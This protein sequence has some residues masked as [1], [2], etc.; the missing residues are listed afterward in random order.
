[1]QKFNNIILFGGETKNENMPI[2]FYSSLALLPLRGKPIIYRQLENLKN[3]YNL[4]EFIIVVCNDNHKLIKY[5]KNVLKLQFKIKLV[6]V[7]SKKNILSSLK[8]GLK[9]ADMNSPTRV[10]LG[11][12]LIPNSIDDETNIVY[13]SKDITTSENWC[14]I[15]N[16][17]IFYDKLKEID[18]SNKE[19]LVGYYAFSDTKY[20]LNCCTKA[21]LLL[22]KEI[23]TALI[24][25]QKRYKLNKKLIQDWYDLGHTSGIIKTKNLLFNARCFNSISVDMEMGL[26]KKTSTKIQKLEDEAF[27]YENLPKEL[28]ILAPRLID[29]T[30]TDKIGKLTQE[31]Y[32]YP[33]LQELYLSGEVNIEDWRHIIEK[34]FNLHKKLE[35]YKNKNNTQSIK[36]LYLEKTNDRIEELIKQNSYWKNIFDKKFEFINNKKY[37]GI[38]YLKDDI[39]KFIDI[40]CKTPKE[41]IIHGDYCFSNILFDANNYIFK[42]I[43][44]RGRMNAE[45]TIYGDPRY[46]IAKLR[47]SIVGFYDFI[48]NEYFHLKETKNGFEYEIIR[49]MEYSI[50]E[51]VFDNYT[52]KNNFDVQEIKFIE[53]LLFLSM[54]PLHKEN[55][56]HQQMFY[57][58]AVELLNTSLKEKGNLKWKKENLEYA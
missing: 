14:L 55:F 32:G 8:Y 48:V 26:L 54:I 50:L 25:Y 35:Q 36:W 56:K 34:L 17:N 7:N 19:A 49:P 12:T 11:D 57:I 46:D 40:L 29:F 16:N 6:L 10:L 44:P 31:L 52:E 37:T 47:H 33:S 43:D 23:S 18:L 4:N 53:G 20:L 3:S 1:M 27:W 30:K 24:M 2:G 28:K 5:I 42:L 15:D 13:T 38:K 9:K 39:N 51:K 21:R 41:T 22:K 45:A 58:K